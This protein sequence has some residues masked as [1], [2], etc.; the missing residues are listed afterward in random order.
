MRVRLEGR[1]YY[2]HNLA[3]L[4]MTGEWPS[5]QIDHE[6]RNGLDN[7]FDNL[8]DVTQSWNQQ[9]QFLPH[10]DNKLGR[11]GVCQVG[12]KFVATLKVNRKSVYLG[13]FEDVEAASFAYLLGK[14]Q[15][16]P[17]SQFG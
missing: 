17:G 7:K 13:L 1:K 12:N 5:L 4:Y 11:R 16:Q 15:Y 14:A 3:W 9:N 6:N 2:L 8:R 10:R